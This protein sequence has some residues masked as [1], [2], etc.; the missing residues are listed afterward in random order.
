MKLKHGVT[1]LAAALIVALGSSAAEAADTKGMAEKG[2][3]FISADRLIPL[4]NY[5]HGSVTRTT[6]GGV[7]LTDSVSGT[8]LSLLF[9]YS[10]ELG[11]TGLVNVH[12]IPRIAFD[13]SIIRHLTLG[14][15]IAFAFGL[16][17]SVEHEAAQGNGK[18][19]TST[20]L[21]STT[22]IGFTP[23]VGWLLPLS[24]L[25]AFWPRAGIGIY[26]LSS[27][28]DVNQ[29]ANL[30]TVKS[31]ATIF[32]LD[33]DPQFALVPYEHFFIHAGPIM[34]I[35][36]SGSVS[37]TTTVGANQTKTT[38]DASIFS[39]GLSAGIGGWFNIF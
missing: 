12:T 38:F 35:P 21:P 18:V 11:R 27:A 30:G 29:N 2:N 14:A 17:G 10:P 6:P 13:I 31:S 24:D 8:S 4:F 7:D 5:T 39:F 19:T 34:N 32:S 25:F 9:G 26:S 36:L 22:A 23:R 1:G 3:L 37:T 28:T 33:L 20:D 15:G 16:G